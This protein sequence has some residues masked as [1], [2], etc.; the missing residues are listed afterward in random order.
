[1]RAAG[2]R[3]PFRAFLSKADFEAR[4]LT[5]YDGVHYGFALDA[6]AVPEPATVLLTLSGLLD[7]R[8]GRRKHHTTRR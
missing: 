4:E 5:I 6:Q 3:C 7:V 8:A 1:M 2:H